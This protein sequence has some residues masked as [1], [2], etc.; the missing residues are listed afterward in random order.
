MMSEDDHRLW[1]AWRPLHEQEY[2]GFY[3][4]VQLTDE[5]GI[6]PETPEFLRRQWAYS[7]AKRIDVVGEKEKSLDIIE[8][9]THAGLSV[10]G[11]TLSYVMLFQA[12]NPL[13]KPVS[14][15]VITDSLDNN[16]RRAIIAARLNYEI[17][18]TK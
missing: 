16:T 15:I 14:G 1:E 9:R 4:N 3:F 8:F 5:E 13:G 6:P 11:Q 7:T 10:I 2:I 12:D 18:T 17:I